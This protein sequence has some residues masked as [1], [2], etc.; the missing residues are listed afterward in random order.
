LDKIHP[1]IDY[2]KIDHWD[3]WS[4]DHTLAKMVLPM[5]KQLKE[6][7]HGS[8]YIDLEDVPEHLRST[9]TEDHDDQLCFDFYHENQD[10][11]SEAWDLLHKR[12]DWVMG[13]MIFAFE[14]KLDDS[15]EDEF[16][17]GE[18]DHLWVK[19]DK[20]H[21]N[22][23]TQKDEGLYQMQEGPNHTYK[24]DYEGYEKVAKRIENGFR[25]FGKYY[26]ALWD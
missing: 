24:F 5:L 6:T 19:L 26:S 21:Y 13:E 4:M 8:P 15:W 2:V 25:L 22:P 10:E 14:H 3:T 12:W 16:R 20:T 11:K 17:T 1:K 9:T 7:K 23:I 18:I